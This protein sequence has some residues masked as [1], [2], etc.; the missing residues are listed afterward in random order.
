MK[1]ISSLIVILFLLLS[2]SVIHCK[3]NRILYQIF[4]YGND[5]VKLYAQLTKY[6]NDKLKT[7]YIPVYEEYALKSAQ[8]LYSKEADF[9]LLC[10]GPYAL[11]KENYK[12]VPVVAI[13][14]SFNRK[15]KSYI[16]T[17]NKSPYKSLLD[18]K[19]KSFT[20][21]YLESFTGRLLPLYMIKEKNHD[22]LKFFSNLVYAKNH[23]NSIYNVL[24]DKAEAGAVL[25]LV[26]EYLASKAPEIKKQLKIIEESRSF[27]TPLFVANRYVPEKEKEAFKKVLLNMH[28]DPVGIELL[29]KL[30]IDKF[31]EV[32][33]KDY[34]DVVKYIESI[35]DLL[36]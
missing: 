20:M 5:S 4:L 24:N 22:P 36:P 35:K 18:L 23:H 28:R 19:G 13:K 32:S 26:Y 25:S 9:A 29:K 33:D 10:S 8:M 3:E 31:Y 2:N 12:F 11:Y 15:Y 17:K 21:A 7:S 14:P 34:E 27:A 30:Q 1:Y 16:F 6:I